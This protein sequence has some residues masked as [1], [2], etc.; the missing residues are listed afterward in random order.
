MLF[1]Y[2]AYVNSTSDTVSIIL[3]ASFKS[4]PTTVYFVNYMGFDEKYHYQACKNSNRNL[5]FP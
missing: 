2:A 3:A 1:N 4:L 5:P